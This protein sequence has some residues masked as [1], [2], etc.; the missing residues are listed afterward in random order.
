VGRWSKT[1]RRLYGFGMARKKLP[2][3]GGS[4]FVLTPKTLRFPLVRVDGPVVAELLVSNQGNGAIILVPPGGKLPDGIAAVRYGPLEAVEVLRRDNLQRLTLGKPEHVIPAALI[5]RAKAETVPGIESLVA[6]PGK[7][8]T[9][10]DG[11]GSWADTGLWVSADGEFLL[12][13]RSPLGYVR[14][15]LS[16]KDADRWLQTNGHGPAADHA[17]SRKGKPLTKPKPL[18]T[19]GGDSWRI[20]TKGHAGEGAR[21]HIAISWDTPEIGDTPSSKRRAT[22]D[23]ELREAIKKT[24]PIPSAKVSPPGKPRRP[25]RRK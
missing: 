16:E 13:M 18:A 1:V 11:R 9:F 10:Y 6:F 17:P 25:R 4:F 21:S 2:I 24:P 19:D 23:K 20:A 5:R 14:K 15:A 12:E 8:K 7:L 22:S 3:G